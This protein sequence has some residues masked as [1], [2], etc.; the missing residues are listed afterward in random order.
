[1]FQAHSRY[2][3]G[4]EG[5]YNVQIWS[6][7]PQASLHVSSIALP[8]SCCRHAWLCLLSSPLET[9][10][11]IS[12]PQTPLVSPTPHIYVAPAMPTFSALPTAADKP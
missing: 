5:T 7:Q 10:A 1:M 8:A 2:N 4:K 9:S 3:E 12:T 6:E 11:T